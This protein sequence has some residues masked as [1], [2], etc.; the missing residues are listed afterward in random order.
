VGTQ[1]EGLVLRGAWM[2]DILAVQ[3]SLAV[4]AGGVTSTGNP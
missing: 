3:G 4:L 2:G 1:H